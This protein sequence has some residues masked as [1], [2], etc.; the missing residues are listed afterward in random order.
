[1][2]A[3][4]EAETEPEVAHR[5]SDEALQGSATGA[6]CAAAGPAGSRRHGLLAAAAPAVTVDTVRWLC[7]S[8][9]CLCL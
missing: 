7:V 3:K 5:T 9:S 8:C 1:M 2:M 4:Q 6:A